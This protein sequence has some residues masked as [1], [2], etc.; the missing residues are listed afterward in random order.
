MGSRADTAAFVWV[1]VAF[2]AY[3][4]QFRGIFD[5]VL[6]VLGIG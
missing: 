1:A 2:A 5:A 6:T 3:L 4:W